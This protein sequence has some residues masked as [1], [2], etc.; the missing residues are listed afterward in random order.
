MGRTNNKTKLE[1]GSGNV[2]EQLKKLQSA[3]GTNRNANIE[4]VVNSEVGK[5]GVMKT[6][7][8]LQRKLG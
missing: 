2:S 1:T 3:L 7:E 4:R 6:L 5:N 8:N